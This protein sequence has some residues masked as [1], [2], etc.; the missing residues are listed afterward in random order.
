MQF[1]Y[2]AKGPTGEMFEGKIEAP[3]EQVAVEILQGRGYTVLSLH[4]VGKDLLSIDLN[5]YLSRPNNKDI[6]MFTRQLATLVEAD[7]PLSEGLRTL[8]KQMEKP[9]FR[10]VIGDISDNVEGGSSLSGAL[11]EYPKLFS[12]F[13][14]KLVRS[15]ELSGKLHDSLMYLADYLE[16][17]QAINSKIKGALAY[18]AFVVFAMVI[19]TMILMIYVLPQ[20]LAIFKESGVT[21]L[22]ITTKILIASTNFFNNH[23]FLI[24][25]AMI[26]GSVSF[27][28]YISTAKGKEWFD[29]VKI[30]VPVFGRI[31]KN[32]Y[33][34]RMAESL[35]T[36]I[37]SGISILDGIKITSDL[38]DNH[39]FQQLLLEAEESVR[40][41]GTISE[42][43]GKYHEIPPLMTSMVAIG[44]R[45]GKL[46]YMLGHISKFYRSES[47]NDIQNLSQL[48]EP[49]LVLALGAGVAILVSSILLPIYSLVGAG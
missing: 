13:Y 18:P 49:I 26:G 17:S 36:L 24:L 31:L 29:S 16:R 14:I 7:M 10:K 1:T 20:L 15:G 34:A 47:E 23:V 6:V 8:A 3:A 5:Q 35:S 38:I 44:E 4:S 37:K 32:L 22:P 41:G 30:Q 9:S 2:Q 28:R 39:N 42:T 11:A 43:F 33:L 40:G 21:D 12:S 27:W 45:T 46:D 25:T 19:V 48:I